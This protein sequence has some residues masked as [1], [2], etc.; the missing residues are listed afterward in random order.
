MKYANP[1]F[2]PQLGQ[3][4]EES[5]LVRWLKKEGDNVKIGDILFE[6]ETDKAVLESESF[7]NGTLLK[8][9]VNEN[10]QV[11]VKTVVGFVGDKGDKL[12]DI[13]DNIS[14]NIKG[15]KKKVNPVSKNNTN[16]TC[17]KNFIDRSR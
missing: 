7:H 15:D 6:L 4:V 2:M 11:P 12:P 10:E 8:I 17:R 1:I 9:V 16:I 13:T 5:T 3:T 14:S